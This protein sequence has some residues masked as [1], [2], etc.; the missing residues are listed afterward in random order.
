MTAETHRSSARK[1]LKGL[2]KAPE[3]EQSASSLSASSERQTV[4]TFQTGLAAFTRQSRSTGFLTYCSLCVVGR[5]RSS[6]TAHSPCKTTAA[7][8]SDIT[9]TMHGR[10]ESE[11]PESHQFC[12]HSA[13]CM[14][15]LAGI[16]WFMNKRAPLLP[17]VQ[18]LHE[19]HFP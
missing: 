3:G 5:R 7:R 6:F 2:C 15:L 13:F 12:V 10:T 17:L 8:S 4:Q 18:N 14:S 11:K 9:D 16:N 19:E 1:G